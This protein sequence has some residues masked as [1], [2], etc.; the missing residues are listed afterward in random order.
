MS[1]PDSTATRSFRLV[2]RAAVLLTLLVV[3]VAVLGTPAALADGD[4]ASDVLAEQTVFLPADGGISPAQQSQLTALSAAMNRQGQPLRVAVIASPTDLGSVSALWRQPQQYARFLGEELSLVY[5]GTLLVAMPDGFGLQRV[6][7]AS[8]GRSLPRLAP[9]RPGQ[10]LAAA[11]AG[12][13]DRLAAASG[14]SVGVPNSQRAAA[15][16]STIGSVD[17]GSWL[18]LLMGAALIVLAWGASLRT[19]PPRI[20]HATRRAS[21]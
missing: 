10:T 9:P 15:G 5:H 13:I 14:F 11:T 16:G 17:A 21:G 1:P 2:G 19:R 20:G 8:S 7:A 3:A 12:A 6:G 4:P 18:A